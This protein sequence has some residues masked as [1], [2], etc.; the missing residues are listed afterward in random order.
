MKSSHVSDLTNVQSTVP[1]ATARDRTKY[2]RGSPSAYDRRSPETDSTD[3]ESQCGTDGH[4][5]KLCDETR[6]NWENR[7]GTIGESTWHR[8]MDLIRPNA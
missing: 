7:E 1:L 2:I 8:Q 5:Q 4:E 3:T 6:D